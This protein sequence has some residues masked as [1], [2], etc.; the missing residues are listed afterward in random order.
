MH[1]AKT[2]QSEVMPRLIWVFTAT[3]LVF[4]YRSSYCKF[5][6]F[7]ENFIFSNS[8][9]RHI[10]DEKNL[11]LRHDLPISVNDGSDF[12]RIFFSRNFAYAKFHEYKTLAKIS[13]FTVCRIL[14][15]W[16]FVTDL[17]SLFWFPS[18]EFHDM[19]CLSWLTGSYTAVVL[20]VYGLQL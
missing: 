19:I 10:C 7:R 20:L 13:K 6:N 9:K 1:I 11:R 12:A 2:D 16:F 17:R 4:S 3:L 18:I 15:C 8:V 5:G 14:L